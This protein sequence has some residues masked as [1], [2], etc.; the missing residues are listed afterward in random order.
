MKQTF[1]Y[2]L[3]EEETKGLATGHSIEVEYYIR[4]VGVVLYNI[5]ML[6]AI[7]PFIVDNSKTYDNILSAAKTHALNN[8][9]AA[10]TAA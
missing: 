10:L 2:I 5:S 7:L 9:T 8:K 3:T 6:P 4:S 1:N